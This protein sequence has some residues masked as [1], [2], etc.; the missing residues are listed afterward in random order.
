LT[1]GSGDTIH[2]SG[3]HKALLALRP[4][5]AD[6]P[7]LALRPGEANRAI[8]AARAGHADRTLRPRQADRPLHGFAVAAIPSGCARAA[9]STTKN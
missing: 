3:T 7:L 4:G 6:R 2:A 5:Q 8:V 9:I 1:I